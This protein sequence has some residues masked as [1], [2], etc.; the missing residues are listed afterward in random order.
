MGD[1]NNQLNNPGV[2]NSNE[3][4]ISGVA[5]VKTKIE[6]P[7]LDNLKN[8]GYTIAINKAELVFKADPSTVSDIFPINTQLYVVSLDSLNR[9]ILVPDMFESSS[10]FGGSANTTTNE[11]HINIA[12]YFQQL[13]E[14]SK[15]NTG[16]Y[17]KEIDPNGEGRRVVLGSGRND[18]SNNYK[19]YIHLVYTRIN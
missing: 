13:M 14:G 11:Y 1:L 15:P 3:V 6:F 12:R 5:G 7:F 9:Q 2:N 8:L 4:Y 17:L 19:M 16:L 10:Y 18:L